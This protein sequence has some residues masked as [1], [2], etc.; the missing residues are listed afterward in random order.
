MNLGGKYEVDLATLMTLAT[1]DRYAS[2]VSN[3]DVAIAPYFS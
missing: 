1:S 3:R 2:D